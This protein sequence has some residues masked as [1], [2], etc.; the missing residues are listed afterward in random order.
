MDRDVLDTNEHIEDEE[1][2]LRP[3]SFD[4]YVGQHDLKENLRVFVGA[5]KIVVREQKTPL[6]TTHIQVAF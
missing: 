1:S 2:S 4:E 5:A 3:A 6:L